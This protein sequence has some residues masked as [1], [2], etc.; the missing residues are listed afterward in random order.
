M[1][2]LG[3]SVPEIV[4]LLILVYELSSGVVITGAFGAIESIVIAILVLK[5][6]IFALRSVAVADI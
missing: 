4:G 2:E 5:G 6:D 3:S 1:I